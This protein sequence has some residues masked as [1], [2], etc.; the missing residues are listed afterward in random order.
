[1]DDA[2]DACVSFVSGLDYDPP[3]SYC[4]GIGGGCENNTCTLFAGNLFEEVDDNE[5]ELHQLYYSYPMYGFVDEPSV[6]DSC[7]GNPI[8]FLSGNKYQEFNDINIR[9]MLFTRYYNLKSIAG[10]L[11]LGVNWRHSFDV[12]LDGI[13]PQE[14]STQFYTKVP[15][16]IPFSGAPYLRDWQACENGW[17]SIRYTYKGGIYKSL[18]ASMNNNSTICEVGNADHTVAHFSVSPLSGFRVG[19]APTDDIQKYK[20]ITRPNGNQFV[21]ERQDDGQYVEKTGKSVLLQK[22]ND[23]WVFTDVDSTIDIFEGGLL[24]TRVY[25]NGRVLSIGR[26]GFGRV[27]SAK[28][29]EIEVFSFFYNANNLI[30]N[31]ISGSYSVKYE[32][33]TN[34]NLIKVTHNEEPSSV[35]HYENINFPHALTGI[36]D[37]KNIRFSSWEYDSQG[38]A[39]AS[40]HAGGEN[41]TEINY[42][43]LNDSSNPRVQVTNSLDKKTTYYLESIGAT[44]KIVSVSGHASENCEAASQYK[45]YFL[46]GA[47]ETE[48]DWEGNVT[49]YERDDFQRITLEKRG[50]VWKDGVPRMGI[51]DNVQSL[52]TPATE[53]IGLVEIKTCWH[54]TISKPERIIQDHATTIFEYE[55]NKLLSKKIVDSNASNA[56]CL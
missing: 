27:V 29:N 18:N 19:N 16:S 13:K 31:V 17:D 32:Y 43:Y 34:F 25:P 49:Y 44:K 21:F 12:Q 38:R 24:A 56:Q 11:S 36:T 23:A 26:D 39:V 2:F 42:S 10:G 7:A 5:Y 52:L 41:R 50:Y 22:S 35:Y 51:V 47:V 28:E 46:T 15:T 6:I 4:L 55:N 30:S 3:S 45:T 1:M 9:G 14:E 48:T 20:T 33:D 53:N 40:E 8:D 54:K 37:G